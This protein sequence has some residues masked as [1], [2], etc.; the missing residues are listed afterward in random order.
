VRRD[1]L[2]SFKIG[3]D[4]NWEELE[5]VKLMWIDL[6]QL[7]F[8]EIDV[9]LCGFLGL[10]ECFRINVDYVKLLWIVMDFGLGIADCGFGIWDWG[11]G[12][13]TFHNAFTGVLRHFLGAVGVLGRLGCRLWL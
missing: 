6:N 13:K 8:F 2:I 9:D 4:F 11:L 1:F 5:S 3:C 10:V 7:G 12:F